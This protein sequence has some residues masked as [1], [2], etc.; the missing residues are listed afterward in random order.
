MQVTANPKSSSCGS[1]RYIAS[2]LYLSLVIL[3]CLFC[4][5]MSAQAQGRGNFGNETSSSTKTTGHSAAPPAVDQDVDVLHYDVRLRPDIDAE[6][7]RGRVTIRFMVKSA[8]VT[9]VAFDAGGLVI[10]SVSADGTALE[11]SKHDKLLEIQLPAAAQAGSQHRIA[12]QYHGSPQFGLEFYPQRGEIYTGFMTSQWM[13][14]GCH[15]GERATLGLAVVLP[16]GLA[17]VGSG[18]PVGTKTLENGRE[19][20]RWRQTAPVPAFTYGFAAGHYNQ[21]RTHAHGIELRYLATNIGADKLKRIF[22]DTGVMLRFSASAQ[23]WRTRGNTARFWL[24]GLSVKRRPG[25]R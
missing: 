22:A 25:L 4:V 21:V 20:H 12:I 8:H 11:F 3:L 13:V 19:L 9:A 24:R 5:T 10:D 14:C 23:V 7:L 16:A 1:T 15:P 6:S 17:A 18:K 2:K